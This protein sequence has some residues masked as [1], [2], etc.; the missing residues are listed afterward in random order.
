MRVSEQTTLFFGVIFFLVFG[1]FLYYTIFL[2]K[3][4]DLEKY[5]IYHFYLKNAEG[6]YKG[7]NVI[8]KGKR[9]GKVLS[10]SLKNDLPFVKIA[11]LK[12]IISSICRIEIPYNGFFL[13]REVRLYEHC[14][15]RKNMMEIVYIPSLYDEILY[16][17]NDNRKNLK[18]LIE[19]ELALRKR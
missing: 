2:Q 3:T 4:I 17:I 1:Y 11:I 13:P 19:K 9:V 14:K 12:G 8:Y 18:E 16:I 6:L 15:N 7:G 5:D 10:I